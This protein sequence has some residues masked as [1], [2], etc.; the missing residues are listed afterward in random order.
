MSCFGETS[1]FS[2]L[3]VEVGVDPPCMAASE[4]F[5]NFDANGQFEQTKVRLQF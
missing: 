3:E 2:G 5:W 4:I 1:R